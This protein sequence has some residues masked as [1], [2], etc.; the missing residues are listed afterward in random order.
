MGEDKMV[1]LFNFTA[2]QKEKF[3]TQSNRLG[4]V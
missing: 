2:T 3:Q 1:G 4:E